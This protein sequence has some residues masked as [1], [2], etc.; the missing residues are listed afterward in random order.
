MNNRLSH[1]DRTSLVLYKRLNDQVYVRVDKNISANAGELR[2]RIA[3]FML[4]TDPEKVTELMPL[5]KIAE[6]TWDKVFNVLLGWK[7]E[8]VYEVLPDTR[9]VYMVDLE[10]PDDMA[11]L[12]Q[13]VGKSAADPTLSFEWADAAVLSKH[14]RRVAGYEEENLNAKSGQ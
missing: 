1:L 9:M 2:A 12:L 4:R 3:D 5:Q 7:G 6:N 10:N 14:V 13:E 11:R 8:P